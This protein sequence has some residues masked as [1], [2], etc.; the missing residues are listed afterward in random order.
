[1]DHVESQDTVRDQE[2]TF[3]SLSEE[4]IDEVISELRF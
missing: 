3:E 4:E 2:G 1:M